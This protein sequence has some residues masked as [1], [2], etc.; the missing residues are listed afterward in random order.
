MQCHHELRK[1]LCNPH[2]P[3]L[4]F[5]QDVIKLQWRYGHICSVCGAW[6]VHCLVHTV[7]TKIL[8]IFQCKVCT[9]LSLTACS[10]MPSSA[11]YYRLQGE[12]AENYIFSRL[13][14]CLLI[15]CLLMIKP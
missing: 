2:P 4:E 3:C 8:H 12:N 1:R 13:D 15:L 9:V 7:F 10:K 5:D 6:Y 14:L 11:L